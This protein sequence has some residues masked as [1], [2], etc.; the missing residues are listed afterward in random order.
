MG[1]SLGCSPSL[2]VSVGWGRLHRLSIFFH[3]LCIAPW[4]GTAFF[5]IH[6]PSY[7]EESSQ[8]PP[9]SDG[10][11]GIFILGT[12]THTRSHL[13]R[14][15]TQRHMRGKEGRERL[16]EIWSFV[17][18]DVL[19][20]LRFIMANEPLGCFILRGRYF[21]LDSFS[22]CFDM[23]AGF[24]SLTYIYWLGFDIYGMVRYVDVLLCASI[25]PYRLSCFF[26]EIF[27]LGGRRAFFPSG[28]LLV[29]VV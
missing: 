22:S 7:Q 24:H 3:S 23:A 2:P 14:T 5:S 17:W 25:F 6:T 18:L 15:H 29:F 10:R 27:N 16:G 4:M 11:P 28:L 19:F 9:A 13:V 8:L 26:L 21:G 12:Y 1:A 20:A